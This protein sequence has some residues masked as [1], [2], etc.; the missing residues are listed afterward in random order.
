MTLRR[1]NSTMHAAAFGAA[2]LIASQV[3]GKAVRDAFF[4]S[5]FSVT[6]LPLMVIGASLVSIAAGVLT[7]HLLTRIAA[8][9]L[10][11]HAFIGS[12]GLLLTEWGIAEWNPALAALLIYLQMTVLGSV[13][14]SGF[15]SMLDEQSDARSARIQFGGIVAASSFGGVVGGLLAGQVGAT[16]GI[17]TMLPILAFLHLV[18]AFITW[19]MDSRHKPQ[20]SRHRIPLRRQ[21]G[22]GWT[23]LSSAPYV[24]NLALLVLFSTMGAGLLDY[25]FKVRVSTAYPAGNELVRFFAVFYTVIGVGT[26]LLQLALSRAAVAKLG[27]AGAVSSLPLSLAVGSLG[28]LVLPGIPAAAAMRSGE[29]MVRSSFFKSGYEM[30]YAAIPRRERQATKSILDIG[31][32]RMGDL[33]GAVVLTLISWAVSP[34][35]TAIM[36]VCAAVLGFAGFLISRRLRLGYVQALENSL[37]SRSLSIIQLADWPI[38]GGSVL[39]TMLHVG[40]RQTPPPTPVTTSVSTRPA[41]SRIM[42]D[43]IVQCTQELRSPDP[44]VVRTALRRPLELAL[45][46]FVIALLAWD[47]VSADA[48]DALKRMG[49]RIT[50]QLVDALLDPDQEFAIRRRIPR[51]LGEFESQRAADGLVEGLWDARFE[52]RFH[53]GRGLEQLRNRSPQVVISRETIMKVVERELKV[54]PEVSRNY[55]VIDSTHQEPKGTLTMDHVFR[56]LALIHAREQ[57]QIAHRALMSGDLHLRQTSLEYLENV[58][59]SPL[60]RLILPLFEEGTAVAKIG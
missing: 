55:R 30:L 38:L 15:W 18:C 21:V 2:A 51:V 50:G 39:R 57:I 42:V 8:K 59:P 31:V 6:V 45:A 27:I 44:E 28:S 11:Q 12:A 26:F 43:P 58:L 47:D 36:L 49:S 9:R 5:Q 41:E 48:I 20:R 1:I 29:M 16:M 23:I 25:V 14:I 7:S 54:S 52:V 34:N 40:G 17:E 3:A 13:L 56:L 10:L 33:L 32:E 35:A 24:R 53:S 60:W 37:M 46:P 19:G 4:L 22:A